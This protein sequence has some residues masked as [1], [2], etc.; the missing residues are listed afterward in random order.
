MDGAGETPHIAA[1]MCA[2]NALGVRP[3]GST[4][5]SYPP[6]AKEPF[7]KQAFS[8]FA[9]TRIPEQD[10]RGVTRVAGVKRSASGHDLLRRMSFS[11]FFRSFRPPLLRCPS[12]PVRLD[13]MTVLVAKS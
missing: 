9:H 5:S 10:P 4:L 1:P 13:R 11:G 2:Y 8:Q 7:G 3:S 12:H 6:S